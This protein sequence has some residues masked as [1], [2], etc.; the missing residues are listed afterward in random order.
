MV[1]NLKGGKK[2]KS[3]QYLGCSRGGPLNSQNE[4]VVAISIEFVNSP[5]SI[6]PADKVNKAKASTHAGL[7]IY[8]NIDPA[9]STKRPEKLKQ[10][11]LPCV[12]R[13]VGYPNRILIVPPPHV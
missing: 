13:E 10:I 3:T 4:I 1:L 11:R 6:F 9:D 12:L 5:L 8:S 7:L 2:L